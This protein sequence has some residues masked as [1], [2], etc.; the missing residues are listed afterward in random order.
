MCS[1]R[2]FRAA[3]KQ[4]QD[5][6]TTLL[7][8]LPAVAES[9]GPLRRAASRLGEECG[10]GEQQVSDIALAVSEACT[11]AVI[12]AYRS[13]DPGTL[14][15][16]A[17]RMN[18]IGDFEVRDEGEGLTPRA[19]S[20]GLGLGLPMIARLTDGFEVRTGPSGRG[21]TVSMRFQLAEAA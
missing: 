1:E 17:R 4:V 14:A 12:H 3:R 8:E 21:T 18:G 7:A 5:P 2:P 6:G 16:A 10:A 13:E 19:D 15:L 9:V 20:P 11:N